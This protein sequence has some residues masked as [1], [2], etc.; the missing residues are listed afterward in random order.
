MLGRLK[1]EI[2]DL[3]KEI[4]DTIPE[5]VW[6]SSTTTFLDPSM[7]GGQFVHAIEQRLKDAGHSAENIATRVYGYESNQ[8]RINYAVNKY[9]LLGTYINSDKDFVDLQID[10]KVDVL[11]GSPSFKKGAGN[12]D[13]LY[14]IYLNKGVDQVVKLGG[15]QLFISPP[16]FTSGTK[17]LT[18]TGRINLLEKFVTTHNLIELN[19]NANN[20]FKGVGS[21]FVTSI[22]EVG[23]PYQGTTRI[24]S[25][26]GNVFNVDLTG[27]SCLPDSDMITEEFVNLFTAMQK[28]QGEKFYFKFVDNK[29]LKTADYVNDKLDEYCYEYINASSNH[30]N[31][32]AKIPNYVGNYFVHSAYLG[33]KFKFSYFLNNDISVMHNG[34]V[35]L[36][37]RLKNTTEEILKSV[38]ESDLFKQTVYTYKFTQ[39]NEMAFV[40]KI[41]IPPLDRVWKNSD[42]EK[43]Y[44]DSN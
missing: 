7:G 24:V 6:S 30:E 35:W 10:N 16:T 19:Y 14:P 42:L 4:L 38:F 22:V 36:D 40:N 26:D 27:V 20:Y 5:K 12:S 25:K 9:G 11:I 41:A 44:L 15:L 2:G 18:N 28:K 23:V 37:D 32:F 31:K 1:F 29:D 34:R 17:Q 3:I 13:Q 39:Y 21:Q 33:S 43:W 8:M